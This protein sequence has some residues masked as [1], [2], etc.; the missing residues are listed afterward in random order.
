MSTT[1]CRCATACAAS[2]PLMARMRKTTGISP[3]ETARVMIPDQATLY[4]FSDAPLGDPLDCVV[5]AAPYLASHYAAIHRVGPR[6]TM[7][8]RAFR[9]A[10]EP[11]MDRLLYDFTSPADYNWALEMLDAAPAAALLGGY[12]PGA[13]SAALATLRSARR[14]AANGHR[15]P[16]AVTMGVLDA[17]PASI[18]GASLRRPSAAITP[19]SAN[20]LVMAVAPGTVE[21]AYAALR[22]MKSQ[23]AS[24]TVLCTSRRDANDLADI[25]NAF[26]MAGAQIRYIRNRA[27]VAF[28]MAGA[29][30]L[31]DLCDASAQAI[32]DAAFAARCVGAPVLPLITPDGAAKAAAA[33]AASE[34]QKD[35]IAA[36]KFAAARPVAAFANDLH[37]LIE[38]GFTRAMQADAAA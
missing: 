15:F 5:A 3:N 17:T 26:E 9:R 34:P 25:V 12:S 19:A 32:S 31:I 4:I 28:A 2:T 30:G 36:R 1:C 37:A 14:Y 18:T 7:S 22:G 13:P 33:F 24:L 8:V 16:P 27:S 21:T 20:H 11:G 23:N 6:R 35:P 10:Y 38:A 29:G